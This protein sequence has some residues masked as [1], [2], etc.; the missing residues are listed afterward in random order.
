M[1]L[2]TAATR[3]SNCLVKKQE[4]RIVESEEM[5][6]SAWRAVLEETPP[7]IDNEDIMVTAALRR[8]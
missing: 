1:E 6:D 2:K 8:G 3:P 4:A 7:S 5:N